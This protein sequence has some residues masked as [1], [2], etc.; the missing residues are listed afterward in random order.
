MRRRKSG[1]LERASLGTVLIVDDDT[2]MLA[3]LERMVARGG[4]DVIC[5][6][7][8][9]I[10]RDI[11]AAERPTLML[12]DM[13][14]PTMSGRE[15]AEAVHADLGAAAPPVVILTGGDLERAE[16]PAVAAVAPKPVSMD[17]LLDLLA[18]AAAG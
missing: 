14:M 6:G 5:V 4:Y 10:A 1:Q 8:P 7:D 12:S 16:S 3:T 2:G 9:R 15:L 18:A 17:R 11:A 13:D